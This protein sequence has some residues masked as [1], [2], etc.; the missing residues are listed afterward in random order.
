MDHKPGYTIGPLRRPG[1][2]GRES[3]GRAGPDRRPGG[4]YTTGT[5]A[6]TP[7]ARLQPHQQPGGD[8]IAGKAA[9]ANT[10][11]RLFGARPSQST[12]TSAITSATTTAGCGLS[13]ARGSSASRM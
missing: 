10:S 11:I 7:P 4:G 9:A 5:A 12:P 1:R 6:A 8:Y 3:A 13:V 2:A